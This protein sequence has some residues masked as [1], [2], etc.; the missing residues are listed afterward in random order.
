VEHGE[1][2]CQE[3]QSHTGE[4]LKLQY[5]SRLKGKDSKVATSQKKGD[6]ASSA[7]AVDDSNSDGQSSNTNKSTNVN[8]GM[9]VDLLTK[10]GESLSFSMAVASNVNMVVNVERSEGSADTGLGTFPRHETLMD[11]AQAYFIK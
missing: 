1:D 8:V 7:I 9:I 4:D 11:K 5:A 10:A 2:V 3:K 6:V